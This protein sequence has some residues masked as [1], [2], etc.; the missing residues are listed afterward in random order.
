MSCAVAAHA[1]TFP[2]DP[3][4]VPP[5]PIPRP[6]AGRTRASFHHTFSAAPE[7][8]LRPS[9]SLHSAPDVPR[10]NIGGS[11]PPC[12]EGKGPTPLLQ[13]PRTAQATGSA[14]PPSHEPL[15]PSPRR[16]F[17]RNLSSPAS[18][19]R[20]RFA[21]PAAAASSAWSQGYRSRPGSHGKFGGRVVSN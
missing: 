4:A 8:L 3:A 14:P 2:W 17:S 19:P 5:S 16:G 9:S 6:T 11:A 20:T 12:L 10:Q 1:L 13:I 7:S 21:C 15:F 18:F